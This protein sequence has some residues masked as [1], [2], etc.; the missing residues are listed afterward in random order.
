MIHSGDLF[1]VLPTL[2]AESIDACVTDP[3]YGLEFMGKEWDKLGAS[4]EQQIMQGRKRWT[5]GSGKTVEGMAGPFGGGG[6]AVRYGSSAKSAQDWHERWAREVYRVLKPGAY[7]VACG[8]SRTSH[9]MVCAIEDAGFEIRDSMAW[10]YGSGFPKN[11]NLGDGKGTAL[12]PAHEPI[13]LA[14]K[15]FKGTIKACHKQHGTAAL[16][17]EACRVDGVPRT[18]HSDGNRRVNGSETSLG[19]G[20]RMKPHDTIDGPAWPLACQCRVRR[21]CGAS[22]R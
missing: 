13:A 8:G 16:N 18:T 2:E 10:L 4:V 21:D 7:L 1:D 20:F 9:R 6:Q 12:K 11:H 19:G 17:I 3:P 22:A 15:P 14:W 5:G